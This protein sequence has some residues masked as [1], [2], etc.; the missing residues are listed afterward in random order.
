[1]CR[2]YISSHILSDTDII[3]GYDIYVIVVFPIHTKSISPVGC[4][5]IRA[6]MAILTEAAKYAVHEV[7]IN[8]GTCSFKI[9]KWNAPHT[10]NLMFL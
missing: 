2:A 1:M 8:S 7:N 10:F 4:G 3:S 6:D 9:D 5:A